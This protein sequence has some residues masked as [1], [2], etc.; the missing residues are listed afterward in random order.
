MVLVKDSAWCVRAWVKAKKGMSTIIA[1]DSESKTEVVANVAE[2]GKYI[3]RIKPFDEV[4]TNLLYKLLLKFKEN[5][6]FPEHPYLFPSIT[7]RLFS[8]PTTTNN[9]EACEMFLWILNKNKDYRIQ[10]I[11]TTC[12]VVSQG[13]R[14]VSLEFYDYISRNSPN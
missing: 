4:N 11:D 12:F 7:Y 1:R 6:A 2:L 14:Q 10:R 13:T 9:H 5:F 8:S 3:I